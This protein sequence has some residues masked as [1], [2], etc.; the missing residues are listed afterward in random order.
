VRVDT[1]N[2]DAGGHIQPLVTAPIANQIFPLLEYTDGVRETRTG[3]TRYNQGLE[4][5]SLNKTATGINQILG[6]AQKRKLL[7]ARNFAASFRSVFRK[8]LRLLVNHQDRPRMIRLRNQFVEMNPAQWN[9]DMDVTVNVGL[10]HGTKESQAMADRMM[11]QVMQQIIMMQQGTQGPFVFPEN[12]HY[13]L[14]RL[15]ANQGYHDP[16]LLFSDPMAQG[17]QQRIQQIAQSQP[18]KPD[19]LM[20]KVKA[21][22]AADQAKTQGQLQLQAQK[23]EAELGLKREQSAA[24]M[25][26]Q[27]EEAEQNF[28]IKMMEAMFDMRAEMMRMRGE[29]ALEARGQS[30]DVAFQTRKAAADAAI[31]GV[32]AMA[33]AE[34]RREAAEY[35]GDRS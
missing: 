24:D 35:Q 28:R 14:K 20:E 7:I 32:S 13:L 27:R 19:P 16:D 5:D 9:V 12:V 6:Q 26:L 31:K 18:P 11:L 3:V 10:G 34:R 23:N 30:M 2:A 33:D 22:I 29:M 15:A 17:T 1:D 25:Q 4:A 21:Q 8:I